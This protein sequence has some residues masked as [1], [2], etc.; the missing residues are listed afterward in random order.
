MSDVCNLKTL[1][2]NTKIPKSRTTRFGDPIIYY[3][4]R[5]VLYLALTHLSLLLTVCALFVGGQLFRYALL[6]LLSSLLSYCLG[7]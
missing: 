3:S 1:N 4:G 2:H 6:L 5:L 7:S